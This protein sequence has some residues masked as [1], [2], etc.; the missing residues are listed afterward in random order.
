MKK[1][2][3][4]F[5]LWVAIAQAQVPSQVTLGWF[6]VTTLSTGEPLPAGLVLKYHLYRGKVQAGPWAE[7]TPVGGIT[8][9]SVLDPAG[10]MTFT[11]DVVAGEPFYGV[12]VDAPGRLPSLGRWIDLTGAADVLNDISVTVSKTVTIP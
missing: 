6:P 1:I 10:R 5:L 8:A 3:A 2:L 12:V 7:V 9:P 4:C 11:A